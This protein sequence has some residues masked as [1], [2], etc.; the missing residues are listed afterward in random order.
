MSN[1]LSALT[2]LV[3]ACIGAVILAASWGTSPTYAQD[4]FRT[5]NPRQISDDT[6]AVF[7]AVFEQGNYP[8]ATRR[9]QQVKD[10]DPLAYAL[11]ASLAFVN[12]NLDD[13]KDNAFKIRESADKLMEKDPL[14]GNLYNA[15]GYFFEG[16]YVYSKEK[17]LGLPEALDKLQQTYKFMD[18]A[19]AVDA[20]DPEL[21]LIK[22]YMD[23]MLATNLPFS[24]ADQAIK[25]LSENASPRYLAYRGIAIAYRDLRQ[26]DKA[27]DAVDQALKGSPDNPE[28]LYLKAQILVKQNKLKDALPLFD[29]ALA[30]KDQ[31]PEPVVKSLMR[32]RDRTAR[33][34][35]ESPSA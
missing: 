34:I 18:A 5:N 30:K 1:Q 3:S 11:K 24:D 17:L 8:E 23:L 32:E 4:P 35:S 9:L 20:K 25:R 27:L 33:K 28:V 13:F 7:K 12:N 22:G 31:L 10:D 2:R 26:P 29:Q 19:E 16:A 6:E 14:R 15:V 21:S